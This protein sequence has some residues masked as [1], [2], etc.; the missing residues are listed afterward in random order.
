MQSITLIESRLILVCHLLNCTPDVLESGK[1]RVAFSSVF[2]Y[3]NKFA[4]T[5]VVVNFMV[6]RSLSA[7]QP[8]ISIDVENMFSNYSASKIKAFQIHVRAGPAQ[9][10]E[11]STPQHFIHE[12]D[13]ENVSRTLS[14]RFP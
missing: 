7:N 8:T 2:F 5:L 14:R 13:K 6:S 3:R 4:T 12:D 1:F 9:N 11:N 10:W